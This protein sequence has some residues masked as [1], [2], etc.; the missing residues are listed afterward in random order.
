MMT[1]TV[2]DARAAYFRANGFSEAGYQD[3]WVR[4]KLFGIPLAFPSSPSR[5]RS[6]P[7]HDLHHVATG[8]ETT[9]TGEAE[10]GAW[11]IGG[12]CAE[13]TAA[14]VLNTL[15]MV[16][17]VWIA[18]RRVYR[19][20]MRG[21]HSRTL[22]K[23]G[24]SDSL[25]ELTVEELRRHLHLDQPAT[26]TWRDRIAFAAWATLALSPVLAAVVLLFG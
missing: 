15:T 16:Y 17:G 11:E 5:K 12:G 21:R 7:L 26:V 22:Y 8:Y 14:W 20:F 1:T 3:D 24:W 23:T 25:L 6:V 2:R 9:Y 19:A 13:H 4:L 10:I 18:P